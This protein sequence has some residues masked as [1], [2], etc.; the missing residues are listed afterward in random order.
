MISKKALFL[1]LASYT[2][3]LLCLTGLPWG[4]LP[5]HL[6]RI[7]IIGKLLYSSNDFF[8]QNYLFEW[9]FTPYILW[10][11]L[12]ATTGK[13]LPVVA[14]GILW[15]ELTFLSV[16]A[17]GWYLARVRLQHSP[18]LIIPQ[19]LA[20]LIASAWCFT[21]GFFAYQLSLGL[22]LFA[23]G[24]GHRL[25]KSS[26]RSAAGLYTVY[27]ILIVGCYLAHLGGYLALCVISGAVA[28]AAVFGNPR[29]LSRE[30]CLLA[31][32]L[33][34]VAWQALRVWPA[35]GGGAVGYVY[36]GALRKFLALASPWLRLPLS[37]DWPLLLGV[38]LSFFLLA[39]GSL[40]ALRAQSLRALLKN[41]LFLAL[42]FL[43]AAYIVLPQSGFGGQGVDERMVPYLFYFA[44]L[45]LCSLQSETEGGTSVVA[46]RTRAE[47]LLFATSWISLGAL[48]IQLWPYNRVNGAYR[49]LL[50]HVP[51]H[52]LV[53]P[54]TTRTYLGRI[55]PTLHQG[56]LYAALREGVVPYIF[57]RENAP[58]PFFRFQHSYK[59]PDYNWYERNSS[60]DWQLV[61]PPCN[62]L[63]VSKPFDVAR[64][65]SFG[66]S[67]FLENDSA[68]VY[69][70]SIH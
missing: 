2:A 30:S 9:M 67:V 69:R 39:A 45:W 42:S 52:Q 18:E 35:Q 51:E 16:V 33:L 60:P 21:L 43:L 64:L 17:G 26:T 65:P 63:V 4:D 6:T 56:N 22:S 48:F 58:I 37:W 32:Q 55:T 31:P 11:L 24:I 49:D 36:G 44:F 3:M 28:V 38:V 12:A 27:C 50:Q 25:R 19:L 68:V 57:N 70:M 13:I 66:L 14:N 29:N 5:N 10:D 1:L 47:V 15:T 61:K 20:I 59:V 53:L 62:Y 46:S 34:L 40:P 41:D 54:V 23:I 8:R 7:T